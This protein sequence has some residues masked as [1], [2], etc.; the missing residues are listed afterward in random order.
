MKLNLNL[1]ISNSRRV[2]NFTINP[3]SSFSKVRIARHF[4]RNRH[5]L[6]FFVL[7]VNVGQRVNAYVS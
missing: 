4:E 6:V 5:N 7:S 3:S 1:M 2:Q